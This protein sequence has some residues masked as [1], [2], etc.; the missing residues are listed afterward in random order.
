LKS[1]P[2]HRSDPQHP[3]GSPPHGGLHIHP[4]AAEH[5]H[6][7]Q[8]HHGPH[9]QQD[10]SKQREIRFDGLPPGQA[11]KALALLAGLENLKA[12]P[13]NHKNA[14]NVV[15]QLTEYTFEGLENALSA[16]GFHLDNS[17]YSKVVRAIVYFCEDT[18]LRNLR[19]PER[20]IKKSNEVYV[21]AWDH[22]PH[23]DHDDTPPELR[24][25]K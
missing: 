20:L 11:A 12:T 25:Y 1:H 3:A 14:V 24:E 18:Q 9:R 16:Q 19:S 15:Y 4:R 10:T 22:H 5:G 17:L 2:P 21:K 8:G 23:G 13:G 7:H 6:G